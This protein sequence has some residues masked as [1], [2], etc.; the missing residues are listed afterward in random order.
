MS[1][2]DGEPV[3]Y[4][5]AG[6]SWGSFNIYG[7]SESVEQVRQMQHD[8][9]TVPELKQRINSDAARIAELER[10]R[11]ALLE[12]CKAWKLSWNLGMSIEAERLRDAAIKSAGGGK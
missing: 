1:K 12:A 9:G 5:S 8:A 11:D 4:Q 7:S 10:Q 3:E 6:L 2:Q